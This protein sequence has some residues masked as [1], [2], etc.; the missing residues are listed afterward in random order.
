MK[1]LLMTFFVL[2]LAGSFV[3]RAQIV[4]DNFD[5]SAANN[6]YLSIS[7]GPPS[8]IELTD[9]HTDFYEGTGSITFKAVL[10]AFHDWGTYTEMQ[11]A[12]PD[13][14]YF[15][16]SIS[17]SLSIWVK[18]YQPASQ[19]AN[20]V[21]RIQLRDQPTPDDP[22]EQYVYENIATLDAATGWYNL[23]LS[24]RQIESPGGS[25][26]PGDSGFVITPS[27]WGL[28][29]NNEVLDYDKIISYG[30]VAVTTANYVDSVVVGFDNLTRFGFR[31][32]PAIIFN[33]IAIPSRLSSWAWGQSALSVEEGAGILPNTNALKWTQGDEWSNGWTGMGFT[34]DPPFNLAGSWPQDSVKF[35]LKCDPGVG[36][37]RIQAEGGTGKVGTV[38]TPIA[39]GQWHSYSFALREMLYQ[40][41]SSGFDSSSVHVFGMMAEGT[42]VAGKV[43]YIT[44]WWTGNP[45]FDVIPP[46]A[47]QGV[48]VF[49]GTNLNIVQWQDVAGET[50]EKY[51]VYYSQSPITSPTGYGVEVAKTGV[52]ENV[53]LFEHSLVAP[54]T[55][56]N[57]T[58]YYAVVCKDAAGNASTISANSAAITNE[59]KGITTISLSPPSN[60]AAD[61]DMSEWQS[62]TPIRMFPSDGSG[63]VVTNTTINGDADLSVLSYV[64]MDN[65][66]LYVAFDI[67]DDVVS[68]NPAIASYLN[69]APD[70]FIGLY[71][72]HGA[73]HTS[74]R[75]GI[76][77]DYHFRF[78]KDK[79]IEDNLGGD[80]LALPGTDY[81]WGEKFPTGYVV[82][83]RIS[84]ADIAALAGDNLFVPYEGYR[85]PID[86]SIND[87]DASG[88]REGILTFSPYNEDQSWNDVSRWLYTWIGAL[89][90]PVGVD[91]QG[92]NIYDYALIQNYP[93]PFNPS[94]Q[95]AYS[96]KETGFVSLK[97]FDILGREVASLVNEEQNAGVHTVQFNAS[98]FS[99]GIY[100]YRLESGS[101]VQTNKMMLLK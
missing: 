26:N 67:E 66:Y 29:K 34:A 95:I 78:A 86:Y 54:V 61:G 41:G 31:S 39:D 56:Q 36:A 74:Y 57:V 13:G 68:Y 35:K 100:F 18:V 70:L 71:S 32:V 24:L 60:F 80:T 16:W 75:R 17:D 92:Q 22:V 43:V 5:S 9:N 88:T 8:V 99:S 87:A 40:D 28:S 23:R 42:G 6:R 81:Y 101:F 91:D 37:L 51:D 69:D 2:L 93:N 27:N 14:E 1:N 55:N 72:W 44:D 83:A 89:W 79:L 50:G 48:S 47:P 59:A 46:A 65:S 21:F 53:Q 7:E 94:T 97:V 98:H 58:Y 4:I 20:M 15:D 12:A 33:G 84:F 38:F 25:V 19:P 63:H 76:T 90:H 96:I 10:G 64:A 49:A 45:V 3:S 77:P 11:D 85:I 62:I 82:E 30:L 73:P 52:T